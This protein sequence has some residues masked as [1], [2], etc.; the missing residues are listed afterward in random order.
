MSRIKTYFVFLYHCF[1]AILN[2]YLFDC[3]FSLG[4]GDSYLAIAPFVIPAA[5]SLF[6]LG[7]NYFQKQKAQSAFSDA[8]AEAVRLGQDIE[9]R[10]F[11][12]RYEALQA[13]LTGTKL[14]MEQVQRSAQ[15]TTESLQ[16]GG[17]RASIGGAGRVQQGVTDASAKVAARLDD[18]QLKIDDKFMSEEQRIG[19]MNEKKDLQLQYQRL[20]G[21]QGAATAAGNQIA[22]N[23]SAM[24]G[25]VGGLISAGIQG[26][27]LYSDTKKLADSAGLSVKDYKTQLLLD[28][29]DGGGTSSITKNAPTLRENAEKESRKLT[30]QAMNNLSRA[31]EMTADNDLEFDFEEDA[32]YN[33]FTGTGEAQLS[34][35]TLRKIKRMIERG[36][37]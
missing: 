10:K 32:D 23:N 6:K 12:N 27:G 18:I 19:I 24:I 29:A 7:A 21:A 30:N 5:I 26:A 15:S 8:T 37:I 20:A 2:I 4:F 14:Q 36:E 13:P 1:L 28:G 3:I 9:K 25:A 22:E 33:E 35:R 16:E 17:Q 11:I 31:P 34:P